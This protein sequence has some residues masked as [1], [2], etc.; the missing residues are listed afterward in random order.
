MNRPHA[1]PINGEVAQGLS[2]PSSV[3]MSGQ[4]SLEEGFD[5]RHAKI[6]T[7]ST[8]LKRS[9]R[10][11]PEAAFSLPSTCANAPDFIPRISRDQRPTAALGG[12]GLHTSDRPSGRDHTASTL[13][14]GCFHSYSGGR[15]IR[16]HGNGC[17][18]QRF[19][20]PPPSATRR[21]L[22]IG[23]N[24]PRGVAG[25]RRPERGYRR[26]G[27]HQPYG[28]EIVDCD[29]DRRGTAKPSATVAARAR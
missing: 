1:S 12:A 9:G 13:V 25:K 4:R 16:T 21:A 11:F 5:I 10:P 3:S 28:N 27:P 22:P 29:R 23:V 24:R 7:L 26:Y 15:G 6:V 20:R 18:S 17:P 8:L 2:S 19:S 14:S